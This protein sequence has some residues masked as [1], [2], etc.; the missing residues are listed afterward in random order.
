[1]IFQGGGGGDSKY[2]REGVQLLI[3]LEKLHV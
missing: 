3:P 1:M 2:S